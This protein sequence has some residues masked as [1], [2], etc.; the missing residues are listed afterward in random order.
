MYNPY[1]QYYQANEQV[2]QPIPSYPETRQTS[3]ALLDVS[4]YFAEIDDLLMH[5]DIPSRGASGF[6]G[7]Y[8]DV[9]NPLELG[10]LH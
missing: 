4:V 6:Y 3:L 5:A 8:Q 1:R 10:F 7:P 2:I 9:R